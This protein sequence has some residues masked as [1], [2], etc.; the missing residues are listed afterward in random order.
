MGRINNAG[1]FMETGS[2]NEE[3]YISLASNLEAF[4]GFTHY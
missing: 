4:N 3:D 1:P 2:I